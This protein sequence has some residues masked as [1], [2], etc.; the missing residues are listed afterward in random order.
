MNEQKKVHITIFQAP[1][2][3]L[4]EHGL[5]MKMHDPVHP[6]RGTVPAEYYLPVFDGDIELPEVLKEDQTARTAVILE[7]VFSIFNTAHPAGYCGRSLS[8]GDI[9]Q[10]EGRHYL[11]AVLGFTAVDFRTSQEH[12]DTEHKVFEIAL[13]GGAKLV[14][15]GVQ[16]P[17]FPSVNITLV[18]ADHEESRVCFV[19]HNPEKEPEHE[20]CVGVYCSDED[21]TVYYDSYYKDKESEDQA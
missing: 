10:L 5:Y 3:S 7:Q 19:E 15:T 16:D 13:P 14:A 6:F 18:N 21:D 11:C 20:L 9:V 4:L 8:V 1:Y 17:Q 12:S 2:A